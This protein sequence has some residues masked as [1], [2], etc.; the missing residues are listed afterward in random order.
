MT[1]TFPHGAPG[2]PPST[3]SNNPAAGSS[4]LP[5][6]SSY[7]SVVSGAAAITPQHSRSA[8]SGALSHLINQSM[9][10]TTL[11]Q[12][13]HRILHGRAS[14]RTMD[15]DL[16]FEEGMSPSSTIW[17]GRLPPSSS[18]FAALGYGQGLFGDSRGP[19]DMTSEPS[20]TPSY[21]RKSKYM[22]RLAAANRARQA[23]VARKSIQATQ[24]PNP[25]SLSTS[26]SSLNLHKMAPSHRGIAYDVVEK[27]PQMEDDR[28][29]QLPSRW[30]ETDKN[31]GI[32]L[33]GD[34]LEARFVG[35]N[36]SHDNDS[37]A[38]RA[39]HPMSPA[40]GIYYYEITVL[41][42]GKEGYV[43]TSHMQICRDFFH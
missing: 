24:S 35:P 5:R 20:F 16:L 43:R 11:S 29:I 3:F 36:K 23:A 19:G 15:V 27:E 10:S 2:A 31:P 4:L 14:S 25:G 30:N 28:M 42:K 34:G 21:L 13:P 17:G 7:A 8:G 41:S 38:V 33:L 6:R 9:I 12:S 32:E 39:D 1:N 37:A 22:E 18:Q 26:S 40:C